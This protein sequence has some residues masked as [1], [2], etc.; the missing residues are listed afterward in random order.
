MIAGAAEPATLFR[1]L[2]VF[3]GEFDGV[4]V[5]VWLGPTHLDLGLPEG[6]DW[7]RCLSS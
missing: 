4:T 6:I 7:M 1:W 2:A 5:L 3:I